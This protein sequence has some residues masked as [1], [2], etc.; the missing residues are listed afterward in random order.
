MLLAGGFTV[1][2]PHAAKPGGGRHGQEPV[3][4]A[5]RF[6][7]CPAVEIELL[8]DRDLAAFQP[9]PAPP[10]DVDWTARVERARCG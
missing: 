4:G 8:F 6:R 10:I 1:H 5:M 9:L 7:L 3:E 2:A